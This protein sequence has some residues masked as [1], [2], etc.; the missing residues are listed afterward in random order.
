MTQNRRPLA[1]RDT[2]LAAAITKALARTAITPNQISMAGMAAAALGGAAFW[3]AGGAGWLLIAGALG[4]QIRLLCNLFD[5]MVA[6]EAGRSAPD[7]GFWNEFP[8][9]VSDLCLIM[10]FALGIGLP[11]LG[12]A[13]VSM[14]FLTAYTRELGVACGQAAI[15][16]GPMAKQHRMALLT[17]TAPLGM[18]VPAALPYALWALVIGAGLTVFRRAVI[19]V[20]ALKAPC[21]G[22]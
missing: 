3:A 10:G 9:R 12:W 18:V 16:A 4:C 2:K 22:G 11:A 7:G 13:G 20:T 6:I 19:L 5:G 8:D 14:A 17:L 15:Y 1:S 21:A